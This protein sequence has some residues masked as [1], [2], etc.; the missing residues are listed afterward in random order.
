VTVIDLHCHTTASDG[1]LSPQDLVARAVHDGADVIAVTDHDTTDGIADASTAGERLGV[2]IV[3]GIELSART[4]ERN[5]HVLGYFLDPTS[6]ELRAALADLRESRAV[7]AERIV[8]RLNELGYPIALADV[9]AQ[10]GSGRVLARPHIARALVARELI[11]SVKQAFGP[12]LLADGG[13]ADVPKKTLTPPEAVRLIRTAGGAPVIA[14]A[15]VGHHDG[16]ARGVPVELIDELC[17]AG[18]AGVEVDHPDHPPL[19][20]DTLR[21]LAADRDLVVTGGSDFHGDPGHVLGRYRTTADMLER[22]E[23]EAAR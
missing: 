3:P 10:A 13:R 22:L 8:E 16:Q 12:D 5:V 14:H 18:L 11:G 4:P 1:T 7:R 9:E 19:I 17:A 6:L 20:R 15:A 2:R 23:A 21:A